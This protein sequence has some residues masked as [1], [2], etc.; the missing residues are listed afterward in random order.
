[1]YTLLAA[2]RPQRELDALPPAIAEGIRRV[3]HALAEDPRS[4][5]FDVKA[6]RDVDGKPPALRLRVGDYRVVFA[7]D[8]TSEEILVARIGHRKTVYRGL[9]SSYD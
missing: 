8:H 7:M 9:P 5:R 6:L 2:P 1:M 4:R 3:L